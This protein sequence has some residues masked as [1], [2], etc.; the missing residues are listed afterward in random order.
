MHKALH[1]TDD[2]DR[3]SVPWKEGGWEL[4]SIEDSIDLSIQE[5]EDDI[6]KCVGRLITGTRNNTDN[7]RTSRTEIAKKQKWKEKQLYGRCKRLI[8]EISYEKTWRHL[9]KWNLETETESLLKAAQNSAIVTNHIKARIDKMQQ[10]SEC[11]L[12]GDRGETITHIIN[13]S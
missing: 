7:T 3:L 8:S 2:V 4:T 11:R 9:R 10:N 5:V 12:Y 6:E 13:Q 1:P